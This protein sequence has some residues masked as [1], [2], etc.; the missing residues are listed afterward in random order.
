MWS[1]SSWSQVYWKSCVNLLWL[2]TAPP[3]ISE[4]L[5]SLSLM[6]ENPVKHRGLMIS[7]STDQL[8]VCLISQF[9][10]SLSEQKKCL[11]ITANLMRNRTKAT[12]TERALLFN[13]TQSSSRP[14]PLHPIELITAHFLPFLCS[15]ILIERPAR[16]LHGKWEAPGNRD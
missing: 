14:T 6:I 4:L 3:Q 13:Q 12:L 7:F 11:N 9:L 5:A 2:S 10:F 1:V 15:Y 8:I 16:N